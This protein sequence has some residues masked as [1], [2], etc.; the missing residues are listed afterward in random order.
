MGCPAPARPLGRSNRVNT[1]LNDLNSLINII[2]FIGL[3]TAVVHQGLY[4]PGGSKFQLTHPGSGSC[5]VTITESREVLVIGGGLL[6]EDE[7]IGSHHAKADRYMS[8]IASVYSQS[9]PGIQVRENTWVLCLTSTSR[10]AAMD[11]LLSPI[12]PAPSVLSPLP[13]LLLFDLPLVLHGDWGS[14]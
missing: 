5:A 6:N 9:Q 11:V 13:F 8:I 10:E 12:P 7:V 14:W 2:L 1:S 3:G 4:Y